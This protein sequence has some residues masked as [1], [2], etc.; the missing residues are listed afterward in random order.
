VREAALQNY[1][2]L[3]GI[4]GEQWILKY[5][6]PVLSQQQSDISYLNRLTILF[7]IV[8]LAD[9]V[10]IE[11][12]RTKFMPMLSSLQKDPVANVRLNVAKTLSALSTTVKQNKESAEQAKLILKS[13]QLD[14][15]RD[16]TFYA[17]KALKLF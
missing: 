1:K 5:C 16:V 10:S 11:S 12:V 9:S 13:L 4:F 17:Q 8:A 15:D 14:K 6:W 7:G 3:C 2:N